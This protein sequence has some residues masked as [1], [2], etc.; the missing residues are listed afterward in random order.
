MDSIRDMYDSGEWVD[1]TETGSSF[2][3][4]LNQRNGQYRHRLRHFGANAHVSEEWNFGQ[5]KGQ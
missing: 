1:V 3:V 4:Q 5:P 2:E